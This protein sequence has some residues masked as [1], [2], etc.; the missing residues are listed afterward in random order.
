[1]YGPPKVVGVIDTFFRPSQAMLDSWR[2]RRQ[3]VGRKVGQGKELMLHVHL[4]GR[5]KPRHRQS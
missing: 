1:M 4:Q 2:N 3:A 5:Q